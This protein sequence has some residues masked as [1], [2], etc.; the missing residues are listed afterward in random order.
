MSECKCVS[1][2]ETYDALYEISKAGEVASFLST[3]TNQFGFDDGADL[4]KASWYGISTILSDIDERLQKAEAA[5]QEQVN[6]PHTKGF[7]EGSKFADEKYQSGFKVGQKH[8]Y[9]S[10][11]AAEKVLSDKALIKKIVDDVCATP[12][13]GSDDAHQ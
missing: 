1:N 5:L 9:A 6:D 4:T 11:K 7:R 13:E 3:V 8:G 10:G 12:E 2:I